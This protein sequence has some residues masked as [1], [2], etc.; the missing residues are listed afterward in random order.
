[1][2]DCPPYRRLTDW[3]ELHTWPGAESPIRILPT[4]PVFAA[5]GGRGLAMPARRDS[6]REAGCAGIWFGARRWPPAR[7]SASRRTAPR[8]RTATLQRQA[9]AGFRPS[10]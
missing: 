3:V 6:D 7:R 2:V 5:T 10:A 1:M 9:S 4:P 8:E